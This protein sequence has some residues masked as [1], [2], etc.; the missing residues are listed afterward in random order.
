MKKLILKLILGFIVI[1][2]IGG[3]TSNIELPR[4]IKN[5][6]GNWKVE[7]TDKF[8]IWHTMSEDEILN[9]STSI[10]VIY[11]EVCKKFN[12][13]KEINPV[14]DIIILS[15]SMKIEKSEDKASANKDEILISEEKI[16]SKSGVNT[17]RHELIHVFTDGRNLGIDNHSDIPGWFMESIAQYYQSD[18]YNDILYET[19]I[20]LVIKA[21]EEGNIIRFEEMNESSGFWKALDTH[22]AYSQAASMYHYLI[23]KFGEESIVKLFYEEGDFYDNLNIITG[24]TFK[25]VENNW[26]EYML[27]YKEKF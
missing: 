4:S 22:L 19:Y 12:T 20:T 9:L 23:N 26:K 10:E 3:C 27:S 17:L 8:N 7:K 25:Q 15:K 13:Y 16:K 21:Y 11:Y 1:L 6:K 5:F 18:I 14:V 24:E 2:I